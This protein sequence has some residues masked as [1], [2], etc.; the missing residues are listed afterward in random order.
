MAVPVTKVRS[1][2]TIEI[3]GQ[4][5]N[6]LEYK[7]VRA[8]QGAIVRMKLRNVKTG[9]TIE[10][11]FDV[12]ENVETAYVERKPMQFLYASE[13][14]FHFMDQKTFEQTAL[15]QGV[16]Q[17]AVP[18]IKDGMVVNLLFCQEEPIGVDLPISV[19]LKVAETGPSV[20]G[21][22][23]GGGKPATLETGLVVNVPFFIEN[24]DVI[25]VDTR[26]GRYIERV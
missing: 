3:D 24:G 17:D 2:M 1:G 22:T 13:G 12:N 8:A 4:V 11:T 14:A 16:I 19:E 9:A 25:K 15:P 10:R 21:D 23:V 20:K 5:F 6:A 26:E 7:H 18:Y